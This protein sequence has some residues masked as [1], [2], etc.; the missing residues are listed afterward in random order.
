MKKEINNKHT[1]MFVASI[2]YER[3]HWMEDDL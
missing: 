3:Q 1:Y 2:V